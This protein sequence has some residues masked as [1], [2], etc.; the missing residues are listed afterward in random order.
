M[1]KN[2]NKQNNNN[3]DLGIELQ[4]DNSTD[5]QLRCLL[6]TFESSKRDA[7]TELDYTIYKR[8]FVY[9]TKEF[10]RRNSI[11]DTMSA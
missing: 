6:I 2:N 7:Q 11:I 8:I 3:I 9:A 5:E 10:E 4:I 1:K